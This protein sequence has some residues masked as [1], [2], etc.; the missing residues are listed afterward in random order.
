M[1]EYIPCYS[2]LELHR[3][4]LPA[5]R[6]ASRK[7]LIEQNIKKRTGPAL[8]VLC[9]PVSTSSAN[10]LERFL[11]KGTNSCQ[12][13]KEL[14]KSFKTISCSHSGLDASIQAK[15]QAL[16]SHATVPLKIKLIDVS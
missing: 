15:T 7:I 16:K 3:G 6:L 14:Q 5:T 4:L 1:M 13:S 12:K 2:A 11:F 10:R 9:G 8:C